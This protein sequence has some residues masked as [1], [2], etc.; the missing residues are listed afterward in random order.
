YKVQ[1]LPDVTAEWLIN[2]SGTVRATFFYKEN[3]DFLTGSTT[4]G[5][6]RTKR[7]GASIAYKKDFD[8]LKELFQRNRPKKKKEN[9]KETPSDQTSDPAT[10]SAKE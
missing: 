8:T 3:L 10:S 2:P 5:A 7:S 4:T 6:D 9:K 1:F